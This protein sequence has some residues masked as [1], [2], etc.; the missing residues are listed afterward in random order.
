MESSLQLEV[1]IRCA[2]WRYS[3]YIDLGPTRPPLLSADLA[4]SDYHGHLLARIIRWRIL[5]SCGELE[6]TAT[7]L[8]IIPFANLWTL[9]NSSLES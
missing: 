1:M 6:C 9:S 8:K 7:R 2:A 3:K 4:I 5:E